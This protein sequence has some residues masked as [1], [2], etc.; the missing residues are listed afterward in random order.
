MLARLPEGKT[1]QLVC[2]FN[3]LFQ[4]GENQW[5]ST[6]HS[7]FFVYNQPQPASDF[8]CRIQ[9]SELYMLVS[10]SKLCCHGPYLGFQ[11]PYQKY[12]HPIIVGIP[13]SRQC[14]SQCWCHGKWFND[15]GF[16]TQYI[17]YNHIITYGGFLSHGGTPNL[18][19]LD[20][21]SIETQGDLGICHFSRPR[22]MIIWASLLEG[23]RNTDSISHFGCRVKI[24]MYWAI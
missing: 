20:H 17:I 4:T 2:D 8:H 10:I 18:P 23:R 5:P 21:F 12:E 19:K 22:H 16:C 3:D 9:H 15:D 7:S 13:R 11:R 14:W 6:I 1:G 24:M